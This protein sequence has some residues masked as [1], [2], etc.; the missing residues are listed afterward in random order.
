MTVNGA[1]FIAEQLGLS[2]FLISATVIAIGTSLPELVTS[3]IAA[4]K[5]EIDMAVGNIIGSNIFN[6]F[7]I[8]GI[9]AIIR[10]VP[11]PNFI[12]TDIIILGI[13]TLILFSFMFLGK[14]HEL[15]RW[16][17]FLFVIMYIAY[18]IFLILRG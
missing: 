3:I 17:G 12:N 1:I 2:Q 4:T 13:A 11:I 18:V 15:E 16:N 5:K 8:L 14:K 9:T 7:W 6:I 10:P